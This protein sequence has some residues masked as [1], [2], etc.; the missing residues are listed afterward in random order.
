[1]IQIQ[2]CKLKLRDD[3]WQELESHL[4]GKQSDPGARARDNRLFI[5]AILW[6]VSTNALWQRIPPQFGNWNATYMRFRR[7][8]ESNFWRFLAQSRIKDPELLRMLTEIADY[9]DRYT[10]RKEMR[11]RRMTHKKLYMAAIAASKDI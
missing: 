1:M 4:I 3:Q 11:L 5:E 7:W 6:M 10:K 8:T 2:E 9:A